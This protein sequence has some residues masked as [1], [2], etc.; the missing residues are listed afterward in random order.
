MLIIMASLSAVVKV[1][2]VF[3]YDYSLMFFSVMLLDKTRPPSIM[4]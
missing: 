3:L 1:Y 4:F 2:L